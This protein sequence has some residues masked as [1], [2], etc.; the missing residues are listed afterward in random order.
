MS[1][2][3]GFFAEFK[4]FIMRGNVID[5]AVGVIIGGAFQAIVSSLV[6]DIVTPLLGIILGKVDFSSL[7][8]KIGQATINYG[9]FITAIINFFIM[10]LVIFAIIK[11][12]NDVSERLRKKP[13]EEEPAPTTKVC[14][15][16]KSEIDIEAVKCP[17]CTS[18]V[19]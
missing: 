7:A 5:L 13:E 12:I 8:V 10:A 4:K 18:D 17:H 9:K 6:D 14:P 19:E 11:V 16:C 15:Y 2:G 3:K 1:K